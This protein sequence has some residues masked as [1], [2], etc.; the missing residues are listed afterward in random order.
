MAYF[1]IR[2]W[3]PAPH[4]GGLSRKDRRSCDYRVY[5]PDTLAGRSIMLDGDVAADVADAESAITRLNVRARAL[6]DTEA[7][8]RLL[9]RAESV[10]SSRIE[11][12]EIGAH[13][14]LRADAARELGEAPTDVTA[15]EVLGNIDAMT[16]GT[17]AVGQGDAITVDVLLEVHRRLLVATHLS[18]HAGRVRTIQN[19]IGGSGYNPCSAAFVP[20]PPESVQPLL[21]DLCA[22]CNDDQL[23]AVAQAAIAHA[24]FETIHPFVDGNGRVGRALIHFVLRRRG[25]APR[26]LPPISLVLAAQA[27][28]Y[29]GGLIATRYEAP[30]DGKAA[31]DGLNLWVGRFASAAQRSVLDA[32]AFEGRIDE[33]EESWRERLG[34]VR[35]GSATDILLQKLPGLPILTVNSAAALIGRSFLATNQA[36]DRLVKENILTSIR[37]GRRNRAFEAPE[38][39]AA[40]TDFERGLASPTGDTRV[41]PPIRRVPCRHQLGR[42]LVDAVGERSHLV[43]TKPWGWRTRNGIDR[44]S[45]LSH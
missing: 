41:A 25:L 13:R 3:E 35:R 34:T 38:L 23:P 22:F 32:T 20:P 8:A 12:L 7:L 43:K 1:E 19:W 40:F 14:L 5:F 42:E 6:V 31:H 15:V 2:R 29:I 21:E 16:F 28:D 36:V 17:Q 27:N 9:L 18:E 26:A 33:L 45:R 44:R 10:A 11:G 37:A 30:P 24:Q 39:I 4:V